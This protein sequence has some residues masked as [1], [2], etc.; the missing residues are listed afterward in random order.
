MSYKDYLWILILGLILA[1]VVFLLC[2]AIKESKYKKF[3]DERGIKKATTLNFDW[4]DSLKKEKKKAVPDH[5]I[6]PTDMEER[7]SNRF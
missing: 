5:F 6:S 4:K 3:E 2:C 7:R 1:L